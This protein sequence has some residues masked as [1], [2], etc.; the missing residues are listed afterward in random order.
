L[1]G[2]NKETTLTNGVFTI[3]PE[4]TL[5][6]RLKPTYD[7]YPG[8]TWRHKQGIAANSDFFPWI[9]KQYKT[10]AEVVSLC[11][12][13]FILASTGLLK[14]SSCTTHWLGR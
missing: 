12:G 13:A 5:K 7:H 10:G 1:V 3:K 11:I 9:I 4:F 14:G 8:G 2:L 6:I